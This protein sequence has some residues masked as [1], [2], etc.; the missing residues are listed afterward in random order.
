MRAR[1]LI[2]I[3]LLCL[4]AVDAKALDISDNFTLTGYGDVRVV[5]PPG[6]VSYVDGGLGKLR[7]G[8]G[9]TTVHFAEGIAQ[10]EYSLTDTLSAVAL[11][12]AEPTDRDVVDPLETYVRYTPAETDALSWSI[13]SGVFFPS[14]SLE[15]DDLGWTSPYTL[16]PSAINSWIGDELRTIGSEATV[17]WQ[18]DFGTLSLVG[19][20]TCCNDEAGTLMADRGWA[21]DDRPT[22]LFERVRLPEATEKL[23][24]A[25]L[26]NARTGMFDEIDGQPGWYAGGGW[27]L[28][29][30]V[31]LSVIRY[32]NEGNPRART[33]RDTAW[34]TRFWA[35]G[36]RTSWQSFTL[37]AQAMRGDTVIAGHGFV[38]QTQ[39]QSAFLLASYDWND[40]RFSAREEAFATRNVGANNANLNE[41]GDAFTAAVSY[42]PHDWVRL[43]CEF[44]A[45]H[46]R[47]GEYVTA[48]LPYD[49]N[50]SQFQISTRLFF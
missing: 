32:D 35:L 13:K 23:F 48:G 14:I 41:D 42:T 45:L 1:S 27:Q 29:G 7:F 6:T 3:L 31:Q 36:A 39:F 17:R 30:I 4:W 11:V 15:N 19:A 43:A 8:G 24:G 47:R 37:I 5:A 38:S 12:R 10:G 20:L 33:A 28:P 22:G 2:P 25:Q 26:L 49:Q 50:D 9:T 34:D 16:T 40:L 46:S 44:I 18:N 21:L